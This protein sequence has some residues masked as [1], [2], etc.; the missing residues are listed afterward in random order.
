MPKAPGNA[1]EID[2]SMT[3]RRPTAFLLSSLLLGLVSGCGTSPISS[4]ALSERLDAHNLVLVP[5]GDGPFP[6]VLLLHAC[7]G[8]L[9]HVD[10]WA[11]EL[12]SR[13]YVAVVVNSMAARGLEGHFDNVAVCSG[14]VMRPAD[15]ARDITISIEKLRRSKRVDL[16]RIGLVGFSHGGWTVLEYLGEPHES[17]SAGISSRRPA[18][19]RSVVVVYP[20]CGGETASG[21]ERWPRGVHVLMLLAENDRAVGTTRCEAVAHDQIARG[22][23]VSLHIYPG[24]EHGY[25]VDPALVW[26]HEERYNEAA[27]TDTRKRIIEFLRETLAP[28]AASSD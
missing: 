13:G 23:A 4:E 5:E 7:F 22:Y 19:V 18:A 28:P 27:A 16:E 21:L 17:G 1:A 2:A 20:Y 14:L 12:Q 26:G 9:G 25:D 24:A 6:A 3:M 15:R 10:R 8:N 11:R